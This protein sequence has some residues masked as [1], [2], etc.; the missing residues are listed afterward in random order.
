ME[1]EK[2]VLRNSLGGKYFSEWTGIGPASTDD[3]SKAEVFASK[4]EAMRSPAYTFSL[5]FFEP[6][7]L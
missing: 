3:V 2:W 5:T 6:T 4:E 7:K 1:K